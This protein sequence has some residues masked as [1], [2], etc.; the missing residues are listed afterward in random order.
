MLELLPNE[1]TIECF[2]YF[3][4]FHLFYSFNGL[5]DRFNKLIRNI[6][7]HVSFDHV[8][9][10]TFDH[11]C[12]QLLSNSEIKQQIYSLHLSNKDTC[13][14]IDRFL[15]LIPLNELLHLQTLTLTQLD[16]E[17]IV[18]LKS[19]LAISTNLFSSELISSPTDED[20]IISVL[21]ISNLKTNYQCYHY[22]HL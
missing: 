8:C 19:M 22:D 3:Y 6:P 7:I 14:Q 5:N 2:E 18:K 13:R 9:K 4:I 11:F 21:P 17:N 1:L 12:K 15:T 10:S 16:R 20:Q